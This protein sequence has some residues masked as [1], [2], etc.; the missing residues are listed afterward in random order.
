MAGS[1]EAMKDTVAEEVGVGDDT[2]VSSGRDGQDEE[3]KID[4]SLST[5]S[6]ID[7]TAFEGA[8]SPTIYPFPYHDHS[9]VNEGDLGK[10]IKKIAG[11]DHDNDDEDPSKDQEEDLNHSALAIEEESTVSSKSSSKPKKRK[12]TT[13]P[14]GGVYEPF[15]L[16]LHLMLAT[17]EEAGLTSAISWKSHGRAFQV[18]HVNQFVQT[19]LPKFFRQTKL[20]SFQRQLNLYGFRRIIHGTDS[21]AYYHELFLRGKPYLCRAMVRTKVKGRSRLKTSD[22]AGSEPDFYKMTPLPLLLE[23]DYKLSKQIF[24]NTNIPAVESG[25]ECKGIESKGS[26]FDTRKRH[27]STD[28]FDPFDPSSI[29][30]IKHSS[31]SQENSWPNSSFFQT[32]AYQD[33][34]KSFHSSYPHNAAMQPYPHQYPSNF[35]N[36]RPSYHNAPQRGQTQHFSPHNLPMSSTPTYVNG[37]PMANYAPP[38]SSQQTQRN[39]MYDMTQYSAEYQQPMHPISS[40]NMS[41]PYYT[42]GGSYLSASQ[43][44]LS[45]QASQQEHHHYWKHNEFPQNLSGLNQHSDRGAAHPQ[46]TNSQNIEHG[47]NASEVQGRIETPRPSSIPSSVMQQRTSEEKGAEDSIDVTFPSNQLLALSPVQISRR[48]R[49]I[50]DLDAVGEGDIKDLFGDF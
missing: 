42:Y 33:Q 1:Q 6:H 13:G 32:G 35:Q 31:G 17:V 9:E 50:I 20:T 11:G 16:K 41:T 3:A 48:A 40:G 49:G 43:D 10:L 29:S 37:I 38:S 5:S 23:D 26:S 4:A 8:S 7:L 21:G 39:Q 30:P 19:I 46:L 25:S 44:Q 27:R 34:S 28:Y 36:D 47:P 22:L 15:P 18:N 24:F 45:Q 14:R 12:G 2:L